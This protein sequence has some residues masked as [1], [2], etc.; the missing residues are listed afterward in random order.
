MKEN[1]AI[2]LFSQPLEFFRQ[3][4]T[5]AAG[6]QRLTIAQETEFYLVVLLANYARSSVLKKSEKHPLAIQLHRAMILGSSQSLP[7]LKEIGD[8]S[9]FISGFFPDSMNRKLIDIDYYMAMGGVAYLTL[10]NVCREEPLQSLYKDLHLRFGTY[11]D[12]LGEV[13][14]KVFSQTNRDLLRLY[15][16]WLKTRSHRIARMLKQEGLIP[17]DSVPLKKQ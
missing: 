17:I 4:V 2:T 3:A 16:K 1:S 8:F 9:L 13:S 6:N 15:E 14:D 12:I 7:L 5:E 10:S 11:V